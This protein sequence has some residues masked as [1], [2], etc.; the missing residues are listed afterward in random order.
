MSETEK[1][2]LLRENQELKK[3]LGLEIEK[4]SS[5][6]F[7]QITLLELR[8]IVEIKLKLNEAKFGDWFNHSSVK[9]DNTDI[10]FLENL[11]NKHAFSIETYQE[12]TLK[13]KFIAPILNRIDFSNLE[14]EV[15]DFYDES[16]T[17]KTEKFILTGKVDFM[18]S[19]GYFYSETPY[20]FIQ[21]FKPSTTA[22]NPQPQLLAE[23][24]SAVELNDW[25]FIKGAYI[26][27][28][29]WHFVILE[30]LEHHKYQYFISQ[31]FDSTKIE[32]LKLIYKNLLFVKNE[33]LAMVDA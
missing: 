28:G 3:K 9:L 5:Y 13:V 18:V 24:I 27:G 11:I 4:I 15:C 19:K 22:K 23:L 25:K 32:D 30:K 16:L 31:N 12:E 29:N 33:I 17:Y 20:F 8:S 1:Q 2:Q 26:I 21:K 10:S 6:T 14:K 7:S